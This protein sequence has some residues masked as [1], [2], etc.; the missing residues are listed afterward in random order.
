MTI[1][2]LIARIK[3]NSI[4]HA[5]WLAWCPVVTL[6]MISRFA[7]SP[8]LRAIVMTTNRLGWHGVSDTSAAT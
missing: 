8:N 3:N 6:L 7:Y 4:R 1:T 5:L 2:A